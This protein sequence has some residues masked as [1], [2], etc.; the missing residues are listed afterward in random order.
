MAI[1]TGDRYLD[2]LARFVEEHA[3][4]LLDGSLVLKLNPVGLHYVQTRLEALHELERL[5]TGAPVDYL[6][7][8]IADLGDHRALEQ[9]SRVL[10]FLPA[11][12][13]VSVLPRPARD[14]S[15]ITL[16][17]FGRLRS[18]ELRGC[19]LSSSAARGLLEL[20]PI[21]EKLICHNSAEALRHIFA[22]RMV[23]IQDTQVWTRLA[24]IFCVYNGM[25]LMD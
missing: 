24:T 5:R 10:G 9:L 4:A 8:Y 21:L 11:V 18:L 25:L 22:E 12:K 2:L 1:V 6:R 3:G 15:P 19:N 16:L 7:A 23:E 13:V 17:P 14:P 20:R